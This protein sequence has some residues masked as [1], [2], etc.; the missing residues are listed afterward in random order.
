ME[1]HLLIDIVGWLGAIVLLAAYGAVSRGITQ[2]TSFKYQLLNGIGSVCLL[3][4]STYYRAFPSSFVNFIWI[5]IAIVTILNNRKGRA[6]VA[7]LLLVALLLVPGVAT[8]AEPG[9]TEVPF[10]LPTPDEIRLGFRCVKPN[11]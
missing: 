6:A 3:V 11:G 9:P 7:R 8:A 4:N 5:G 2:G 10:F 1:H